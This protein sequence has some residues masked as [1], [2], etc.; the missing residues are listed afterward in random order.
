MSVSHCLIC[1]TPSWGK[2][3]VARDKTLKHERKHFVARDKLL[4][5][6]SAWRDPSIHGS[7]SIISKEYICRV[8]RCRKN[9]RHTGVLSCCCCC[10]AAAAAPRLCRQESVSIRAKSGSTAAPHVVARGGGVYAATSGSTGMWWPLAD[11]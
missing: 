1:L 4:M 2:R 3:F 11:G 6:W 9:A 7:T 10:A 8:D 5:S